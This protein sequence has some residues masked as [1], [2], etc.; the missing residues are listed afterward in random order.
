LLDFLGRFLR[1]FN[2]GFVSRSGRF[3]DQVSPP[4]VSGF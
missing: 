4:E 2:L 1:P 3:V